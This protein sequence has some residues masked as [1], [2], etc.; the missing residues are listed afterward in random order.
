VSPR[1]KFL[2]VLG[3]IF[4]AALIFYFLTTSH[5][6]DLVLVGTVDANQVIVSSK[7]PGRIEKLP[8]DEGTQVHA[9]D[10]IAEIDSG[11]LSAEQQAAR[12]NIAA[13]R[14]R[15]GE[16]QANE[17]V[18][19]G[20]TSSD[21]LTARARLQSAQADLLQAQADLE[22]TQSDTDRTTSLAKEGVASQQQA[23]Q[24]TATLKAAQ[25]RVQS[26][27]KQVAAADSQVRAAIAQTHQAHAAQSNVAATRSQLAQAQAQLAEAETRLG[28]TRIVAPVDGTV[29][30]R[31]ARQ[32]EV[33]NA[34][35]PIVTIMDLSNTWVRASIPET[36]ADSIRIGDVLKVRLPSGRVIPGKLIFKGVEGSFATQRDV[37]R[38]KRDINT[39]GLKLQVDN[40]NAMIVPGMTAEV[41]VPVGAKAAQSAASGASAPAGDP[42]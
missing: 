39:V 38:L 41:L 37:S 8:V 28:Y 23:D 25:A 11:E 20:S 24:A 18:A 6:S 13:L 33:V 19:S 12:A 36:Q 27:Q 16:A 7:I 2:I 3:V 15:I 29:S 22:R 34:G 40:P 32:G 9:G 21:V 4:V 10:P 17:A 1:N 31:A 26:L 30:V 42:R 14:A 5:S 35:Q